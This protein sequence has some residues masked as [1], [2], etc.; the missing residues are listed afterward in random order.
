MAFNEANNRR[1][2]EEAEQWRR[3]N[4]P[5]SKDRRHEYPLTPEESWSPP[6]SPAF[7]LNHDQQTA[8]DWLIP[9]STEKNHQ[10]YHGFRKVLLEGWAGTGKTFVVNRVIEAVKKIAPHIGVGM[11][12]PTHKAVKNLR[13]HSELKTQLDFGT[14]HSF[15]GLKQKL[16]PDPRNPSIQIVTYELDWQSDQERRIDSI[17]LL[18]VDEA[19]MLDDELYGHIEDALRNKSHLKVIFMG[20]GLQIP[21]VGN[22][23]DGTSNADA[24]P[25]SAA[26]RSSRK[27]YHLLLN[28]IVRQGLDNPIIA[29]SAA[30]RAQIER[31]AIQHQ[32]KHTEDAGVEMMLAKGNLEGVR[33]LFTKYFDTPQFKADADYVKVIAWRNA[34]VKYFNNEIRLLINKVESLPR[35]ING[36]KLVMDEPLMKG[37]KILL[38]KNEEMEVMSHE[39]LEVPVSYK[40]I[41]TDANMYQKVAEDQEPRAKYHD[42]KIKVYASKIKTDEDK[43]MVINI[44][45]EDSLQDYETILKKIRDCA[46]K[47]TDVYEKKEMWKQFYK[48]PAPFAQVNYNYCITAHKSQGSTYDYCISME[49]DIDQNRTF[50]ERNRI[51]YVAATRARHKLFIIK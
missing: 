26:Q 2:M 40:L 47:V 42:V 29:Y 15:L 11:T 3:D 16:K 49:W 28:E 24:I 8:M 32:F 20:D 4:P 25:F 37:D 5:K 1:D 12:A 43:V 44:V 17:Q 19:S 45:H 31:Q 9:F 18:V 30:V 33:A 10:G 36:D 39:I 48:F 34:T 22:R 21:P 6:P 46:I 51:R 13:K 23:K 41:S 14:I 27:I 50:T 7:V 35:I 38:A